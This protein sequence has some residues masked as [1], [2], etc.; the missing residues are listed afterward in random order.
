MCVVYSHVN[1][2][3]VKLLDSWEIVYER[4]RAGV[5]NNL[6]IR[7]K[8]ARELNTRPVE[9]LAARPVVTKLSYRVIARV[10][11][12]T[13]VKYRHEK[14]NFLARRITIMQILLSLQYA[15][16]RFFCCLTVEKVTCLARYEL[17][18]FS[19]TSI[20][21][22]VNELPIYTIQRHIKNRK[23][24]KKERQE[25]EREGETERLTTR[26]AVNIKSECYKKKK[27]I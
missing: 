20:P 4:R 25:R 14:I 22:I 12:H 23:T 10:Q 2:I 24:G 17:I 8:N 15:K 7:L 13:R 19:Y 5:F 21:S 3:Y 16:S 1:L 26:V 6:I 18:M 9:I 27:L 11:L